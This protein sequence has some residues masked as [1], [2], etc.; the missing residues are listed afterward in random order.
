MLCTVDFAYMLYKVYCWKHFLTLYIVTHSQ[1]ALAWEQSFSI[2]KVSASSIRSTDSTVS[3]SLS[4]II[5]PHSKSFTRSPSNLSNATGCHKPQIWLL[6]A[7]NNFLIKDIKL[8]CHGNLFKCHSCERTREAHAVF[9][10]YRWPVN[11]LIFLSFVCLQGV[12]DAF[13]TLV[14][15]I[16]QHKLR[17]L[18]PPDE[19]GQD[20]MSCRCVVSWCRWDI[21]PRNV[22]SSMFLHLYSNVNV[23]IVCN[24]GPVLS[25][26][27]TSLL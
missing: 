8:G 22:F 18:N 3:D 17:K 14:R 7:Y 1:V 12:E 5:S 19:S 15:E 6:F 23:R 24:W 26:Y 11:V 13:Y 25:K 10:A 9:S 20:C 2:C 16:R 4:P 27:D 21:L